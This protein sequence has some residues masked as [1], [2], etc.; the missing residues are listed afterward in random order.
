MLHGLPKWDAEIQLL[1]WIGL[2]LA[3][4]FCGYGITRLLLEQVRHVGPTSHLQVMSNPLEAHSGFQ[5][6]PLGQ[7]NFAFVPFASRWQLLFVP[8]QKFQPFG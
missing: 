6:Q 4:V 5:P 8:A 2:T 1:T 3:W 7:F